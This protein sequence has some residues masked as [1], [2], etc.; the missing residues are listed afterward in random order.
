VDDR[1][2]SEMALAKASE[3]ERRLRI[4]YWIVAGVAVGCLVLLG[5]V[6]ARWP[7][8]TP[9]DDLAKISRAER[10]GQDLNTDLDGL[11][12]ADE[13]GTLLLT[14]GEPSYTHKLLRETAA[15]VYRVAGSRARITRRDFS[16][17]AARLD[18]EGLRVKLGMSPT[19]V[20]DI[21]KAQ[22]AAASVALRLEKPR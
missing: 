8:R 6:F 16:A 19:E 9:T 17:L 3:L 11:M 10:S 1:Q 2:T 18:R 4:L 22:D 14:E 21:M 5:L 15:T 13:I 7:T 12:T 20:W